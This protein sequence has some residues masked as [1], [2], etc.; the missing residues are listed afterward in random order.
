MSG[1][2]RWLHCFVVVVVGLFVS[3]TGPAGQRNEL[4]DQE[5]RDVLI[6]RQVAESFGG[7]TVDETRQ[8]RPDWTDENVA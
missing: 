2:G 3:D 5:E 7:S 8:D 4:Y 6:E 1:D